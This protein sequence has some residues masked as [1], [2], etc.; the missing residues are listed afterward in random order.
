MNKQS[1]C[2]R[3]KKRRKTVSQSVSQSVRQIG[4]EQQK[5]R[6]GEWNQLWVNGPNFM[7]SCHMSVYGIGLTNKK[8]LETECIKSVNRIRFVTTEYS[9]KHDD[10]WSSIECSTIETV[11]KLITIKNFKYFQIVQFSSRLLYRPIHYQKLKMNGQLSHWFGDTVYEQHSIM[12]MQQPKCQNKICWNDD[13]LEFHFCFQ[14]R[15]FLSLIW[16]WLHISMPPCLFSHIK[17]PKANQ[18]KKH[19][20]VSEHDEY[21]IFFLH[22]FSCFLIHVKEKSNKS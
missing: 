16:I 19:L 8:L 5:W 9:T 15:I 21:W 7:C 3:N 11:S 10:Q 20:H 22:F 6:L 17:T 4:R 18:K 1:I 13:S 12:L 2:S 14:A